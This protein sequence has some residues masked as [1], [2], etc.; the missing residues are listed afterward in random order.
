MRLPHSKQIKVVYYISFYYK[1]FEEFRIYY[2]KN[3][4]KNNFHNNKI[5]N[6]TQ[7]RKK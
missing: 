6:H 7:G 1:N 5:L 4:M 2:N 3:T